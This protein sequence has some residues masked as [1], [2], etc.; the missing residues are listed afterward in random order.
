MTDLVVQHAKIYIKHHHIIT[1]ETS[2]DRNIKKA[3]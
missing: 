1:S 2:N 3:A